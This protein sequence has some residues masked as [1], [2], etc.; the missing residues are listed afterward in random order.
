[1]TKKMTHRWIYRYC[2]FMKQA[3]LT[4]GEATDALK[5]VL[6]AMQTMI[7][8]QAYDYLDKAFATAIA[9]EFKDMNFVTV[10]QVTAAVERMLK[11][12]NQELPTEM[13]N[14]I[15]L[16]VKEKLGEKAVGTGWEKGFSQPG[17]ASHELAHERRVETPRY[18]PETGQMQ[19]RPKYTLDEPTVP[20][21][22]P[23]R[24]APKPSIGI[25]GMQAFK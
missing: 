22:T 24:P 9:E 4:K 7:S 2:E 25:P 8:P 14:M 19:T 18:N 5:S 6:A 17:A 12:L 23:K 15:K 16:L 10:T 3:V 20:K 21:G 11:R 1:M 13:R